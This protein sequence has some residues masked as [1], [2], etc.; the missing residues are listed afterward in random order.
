MSNADDNQRKQ[1]HEIEKRANMGKG[2]G[3]WPGAKYKYF[4]VVLEKT[5]NFGDSKKLEGL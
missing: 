2:E 4:W 1:V 3:N 5:L